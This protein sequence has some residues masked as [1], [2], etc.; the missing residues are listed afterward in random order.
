M[1]ARLIILINILTVLILGCTKSQRIQQVDLEHDLLSHTDTIEQNSYDSIFSKPI[2]LAI[3]EYTNYID[4]LNLRT[5]IEKRISILYFYSKSGKDYLLMSAEPYYTKKLIKGYIYI[6]KH[7]FVYYDKESIGD[8]YFNTSKLISYRDTLPGFRAYED[9]PGSFCDAFGT[10]FQII[11]P[12]SL[13]LIKKG[14]L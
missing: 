5:P 11:N 4:S 7:M 3:N 2:K 8:K 13:I 10:I 14:M 9:V 6:E 12:D 1:K